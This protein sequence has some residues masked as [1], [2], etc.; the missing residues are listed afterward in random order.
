MPVALNHVS[1]PVTR[2][3][4]DSNSNEGLRGNS[5]SLRGHQNREWD[6]AA[7]VPLKEAATE[8]VRCTCIK[9]LDMYDK[10]QPLAL[11]TDT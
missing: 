10:V 5:I 8:Q 3:T 4:R 1:T 7:G 6:V 9:S 11:W 2:I